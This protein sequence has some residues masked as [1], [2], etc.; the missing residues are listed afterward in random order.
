[1]EIFNWID[2]SPEIRSELIA[3]AVPST[4]DGINGGNL[5]QEVLQKYGQYEE[6]YQLHFSF[7]LNKS[8]Q[9]GKK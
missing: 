1:M 2:E 8:H 3:H 4:F 5:T 7:R 6:W 9:R